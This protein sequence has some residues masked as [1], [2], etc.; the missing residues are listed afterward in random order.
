MVKSKQVK[1]L[2]HGYSCV[3]GYARL[4]DCS[5]LRDCEELCR[6][7]ILKEVGDGFSEA[8]YCIDKPDGS[9]VTCC[10]DGAFYYE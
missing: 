7:N 3:D 9:I 8:Y 6:S 10:Y 4:F 1:Q 2:Y 5:R